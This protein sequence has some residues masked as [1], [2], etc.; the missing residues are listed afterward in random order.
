MLESQVRKGPWEVLTEFAMRAA[1]ED[2]TGFYLQ[3]SYRFNERWTTFYRYDLLNIN[4]E[5][6][7]QEHT[8]GLNYRPITDISLK[9]EFFYSSQPQ[10]EDF[11][12]VA[13]SVAIRF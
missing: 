4:G 5:G 13:A 9:L 8:I 7:K 11:N 6:E 12:G 3:P 1:E 2:R 10:D